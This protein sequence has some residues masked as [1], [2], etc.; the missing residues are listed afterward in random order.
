MLLA[1]FFIVQYIVPTT[2]LSFEGNPLNPPIRVDPNSPDRSFP[3]LWSAICSGLIIYGMD[4][5]G[6]P[7]E[8]IVKKYPGAF[9][10]SE[11]RFDL[12]NL[13]FGRKGWTRYYPF[14]IGDKNFIMRIFLTAERAYQPQAPILFEGGVNNPAVT[15]QVLPSVSDILSDCKIK[16]FK[17]YS[18][19]QVGRS[20]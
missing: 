9:I 2:A 4:V 6:S 19:S 5:N 11:I 3:E 17:T 1:I 18:S 20:S 10:N 14:S 15:F 12:A 8:E 16:P 13:E 7:K